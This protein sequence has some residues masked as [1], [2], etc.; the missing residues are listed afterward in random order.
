MD[1]GYEH[2]VKAER[3][4]DTK[5]IQPHI[6]ISISKIRSLLIVLRGRESKW[7]HSGLGGSCFSAESF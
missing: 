3:H 4:R 1:K 5:D 7:S 6:F 2:R